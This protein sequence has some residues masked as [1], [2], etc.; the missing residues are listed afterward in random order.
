M[1]KGLFFVFCRGQFIPLKF[2][3][4]QETCKDAKTVRSVSAHGCFPLFPMGL[5]KVYGLEFFNSWFRGKL[6][7]PFILRAYKSY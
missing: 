1:E 4:N 7:L 6:E 2:F 5:Y 3:G